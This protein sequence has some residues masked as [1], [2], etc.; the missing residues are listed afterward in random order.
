MK[1]N[2]SNLISV[3]DAALDLSK[4]KGKKNL[5]ELGPTLGSWVPL[6]RYVDL[7]ACNFFKR[8]FNT[9]VFV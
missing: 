3:K 5:I 9:G 7:K 4:G 2:Y 8:D 1:I 6:F